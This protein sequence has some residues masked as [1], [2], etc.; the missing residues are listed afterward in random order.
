MTKPSLLIIFSLF[1]VAG[2]SIAA[3]EKKPGPGM[4]ADMQQMDANGD[5]MISKDEFVK[6]SEAMFD[7]MKDKNSMI[8]MKTMQAN[9]PGMMGGANMMQRPM[10]KTK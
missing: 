7:R 2:T 6:S 10:E 9:C 4:M 5:G 3:D 8:D 1:L